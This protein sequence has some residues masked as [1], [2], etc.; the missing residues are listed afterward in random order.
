MKSRQGTQELINSFS[1]QG[2]TPASQNPSQRKY[3]KM[4]DLTHCKMSFVEGGKPPPPPPTTKYAT[5]LM[6]KGCAPSAAAF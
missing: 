1:W 2:R 5:F 6:L 4:V 3:G